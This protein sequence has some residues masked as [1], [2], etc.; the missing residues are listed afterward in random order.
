MRTIENTAV[1]LGMI[2]FGLLFWIAVVLGIL[3]IVSLVTGV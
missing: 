3:K 2:A 1:W